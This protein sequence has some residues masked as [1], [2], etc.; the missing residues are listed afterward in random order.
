MERNLEEET[1]S[2]VSQTATSR[3]YK[4][5]G[6]TMRRDNRHTRKTM[7]FTEVLHSSQRDTNLIEPDLG[8]FPNVFKYT[9]HWGI[10]ATSLSITI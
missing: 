7:M 10:L 5:E 2:P 3:V 6:T 9:I 8:F 1:T 4:S